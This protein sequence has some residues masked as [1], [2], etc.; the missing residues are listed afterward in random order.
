MKL[1]LD[2]ELIYLVGFTVYC[3]VSLLGSSDL[4]P[5]NEYVKN[6]MYVLSS[7]LFCVVILCS[8]YT[9]KEY[10]IYDLLVLLTLYASI[11]VHKMFF[12]INVLAIMAIKNIKIHSVIKLDIIIKTAIIAIHSLVYLYQYIFQYELIQ[13][14]IMVNAD[15]NRHTL[16]FTH[17]NLMGQVILWLVIDILYI[18]KCDKISVFLSVIM[19]AIAFVVT[20][21]RTM[22]MAYVIFLF[23]YFI[24]KLMKE[25]TYKK[26][27]HF[28]EKFSIDIVAITSLILAILYKY[29]ISSVCF[30]NKLTSGRI[31][32]AYIAIEKFGIQ[33][34][35][36]IGAINL[37]QYTIIDNF[38]I[39]SFILFGT[40]FIIILSIMT[41]SISKNESL[42]SEII[43]I[44]FAINLFNE[45]NSICIGNAI[46]ILL[47]ASMIMS[48]NKEKT[49]TNKD[50]ILQQEHSLNEVQ[51]GK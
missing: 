8:K 14:M 31:Y 50:N 49:V 40:I 20:D 15:R 30:I 29:Q 6:G 7:A 25:K 22:V 21:S 26:I 24:G 33:L 1:K 38:Y 5:L 42:I 2:K 13:E 28:I 10:I 19:I 27:I 23:L 12:L 16:Y 46:P 35:P 34:F 43:I 11:K 3:I 18:K 51:H 45:F 36:N 9:K 17:P 44:V 48:K 47:L 39:R 41:K 37:E 32:N 4:L